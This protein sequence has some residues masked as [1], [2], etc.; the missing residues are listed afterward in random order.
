G[1]PP[2]QASIGNSLDLLLGG[3]TPMLYAVLRGAQMKIV[4][5][6]NNRIPFALLSQ[7]EIHTC[8]PLKRKTLVISRFGRHLDMIARP[9]AA[10]LEDPKA[11]NYTPQ[12]LMDLSFLP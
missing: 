12:Q 6:L 2:I 10:A 7:P 3:A 1:A 4:A 5:G 8:A 9:A 11:K